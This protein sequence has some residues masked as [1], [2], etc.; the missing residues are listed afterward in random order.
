MNFQFETIQNTEC[1]WTTHLLD[2]PGEVANGKSEEEALAAA[3]SRA[4]LLVLYYIDA[5]FE[6]VDEM[7]KRLGELN[8]TV[9][10]R[11]KACVR[12]L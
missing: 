3:Q 1:S 9:V 5:R 2:F 11:M 7:F 8:K 12:N 4:V 10:E 6:T